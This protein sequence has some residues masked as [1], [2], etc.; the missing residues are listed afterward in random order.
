MSISLIFFWTEWNVPN[1]LLLAVRKAAAAI[2]CYKISSN[3]LF[4][5]TINNKH[6]TRR[7]YYSS[8]VLNVIKQNWYWWI[9]FFRCDALEWLS[10]IS[11]LYNLALD[12]FTFHHT[13]RYFRCR[14]SLFKLTL[15][16]LSN[17]KMIC[18]QHFNKKISVHLVIFV[19]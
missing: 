6:K 12:A 17:L 7:S 16:N 11:G 1:E 10:L 3:C 13:D 2:F 5:Y 18:C 15:E 9:R 14:I 19:F 8:V 4:N